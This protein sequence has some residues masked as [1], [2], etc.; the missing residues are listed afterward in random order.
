VATDRRGERTDVEA[1][2]HWTA[3]VMHQAHDGGKKIIFV[4]NGGSAGISS[5]L[6]IDYTKNG[7]L[8]SLAFND[9]A[10]L[11]CLGNDLGYEYVFAKQI[12]MHGRT[13][14]VLVAISSSG[15]SPNI[16][17]AV[18]AAREGGLVILTLSGFGSDNPLRRLGDYNIYVASGEY[19]IVE[20]THL[21]L[22]H[23]I[24]DFDMGW[25]PNAQT[26]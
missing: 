9:G 15:R 14:D 5:H 17:K 6:A 4:G 20:V 25:Q 3:E 13:G 24:L 23:A 21:A 19:G 12:E 10:A 8:R 1:T 11:T 18:S 2:L 22:C 16:L 7:G 26:T